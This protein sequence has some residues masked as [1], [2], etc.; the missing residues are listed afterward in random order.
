MSW[1]QNQE[2]HGAV[3]ALDAEEIEDDLRP[4]PYQPPVLSLADLHVR[5]AELQEKA[6]Q[7]AEADAARDAFESREHPEPPTLDPVLKARARAVWVRMRARS[8]WHAPWH[9]EEIWWWA[10]STEAGQVWLKKEVEYWENEVARLEL[11]HRL[12]LIRLCEEGFTLR[13]G[14]N[15]RTLDRMLKKQ[16]GEDTSGKPPTAN[17]M[18]APRKPRVSKLK[19]RVR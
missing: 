13:D 15:M 10:G 7:R 14:T 16:R 12:N 4:T 6:R 11:L 18:R 9:H 2:P 1:Y 19:S 3:D 5:I 8:L 17:P